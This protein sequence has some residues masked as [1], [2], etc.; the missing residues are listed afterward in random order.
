MSQTLWTPNARSA[1]GD[2]WIPGYGT[3]PVGMAA[4]AKAVEEYDAGLALGQDERTGAY[5][6]LLKKGPDGTAY[7]V[8]GLGAT[9]PS[10]DE[11]KRRLFMSDTRR[12]GREI[13]ADIVRQRERAEIAARKESHEAAGEVAEAMDTALHLM[14]RHPVPRIFIPSGKA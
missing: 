6:V 13:V 12:R 9:L 11:I 14:K 7:P 4:A 1:D 10:P 5:V 8:L 2:L 3:V